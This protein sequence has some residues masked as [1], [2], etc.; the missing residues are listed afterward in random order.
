MREIIFKAKRKDNGEWVEG[1]IWKKKYNSNKM[2]ISC[3]PDKDDNE[4]VF[5]VDPET[6]CQFTGLYDGTTWEE[7]TEEEKQEF[8]NKN[9]SEDG[10]TIKYQNIEDV[11]HLWK[12]KMIWENDICDRY[13]KFYEIVKYHEGDFIL[14]YSYAL[15]RE[16]G[17]SYCN[18][19]FYVC[20]R[21]SVKVI[22][23]IFDNPE[24]LE[25]GAE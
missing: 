8:Y 12:G 22:G 7:L 17:D 21:N 20:E 19:G 18:L 2:F 13:E 5:V 4:E 24:L 1:L 23:N 11:K 25:G 16:E 9:N 3:F 6:I 14:D 15:G 10:R